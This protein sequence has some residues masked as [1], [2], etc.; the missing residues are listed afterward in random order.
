MYHVI[1]NLSSFVPLSRVG[2]ACTHEPVPLDRPRLDSVSRGFID[3]LPLS[4]DT[5]AG[6]G[7]IT[8]VTEG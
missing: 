7:S 5:A 4:T 2:D 3:D 1:E 8:Y 6:D